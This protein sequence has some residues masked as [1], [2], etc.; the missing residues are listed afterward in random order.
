MQ[1]PNAMY[2]LQRAP[3]SPQR[4]IN[5]FF[6]YEFRFKCKQNIYQ[7]NSKPTSNVTN[8]Q[9]QQEKKKKECKQKRNFFGNLSV[10]PFDCVHIDARARHNKTRRV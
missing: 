6:L 8:E 4:K 10:R 7:K 3:L 2:P 1:S 9:Q 5:S